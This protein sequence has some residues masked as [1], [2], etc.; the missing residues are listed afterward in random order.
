MLET[1]SAVVV[2]RS[3]VQVMNDALLVAGAAFVG[4]QFPAAALVWLDARRLNLERPHLYPVAIATVLLFGWLVVAAYIHRRD[5]LSRAD[6]RETVEAPRT[7]GWD[8]DDRLVWT[9]ELGGAAGLVRRLRHW[10]TVVSR[11]VWW[12]WFV[13]VPA[14][15]LTGILLVS[16][17]FA[18]LYLQFA[19]L[20]LVV[21]WGLSGWGTDA[22]LAMD[23]DAGAL[24]ITPLDGDPAE[25]REEYGLAELDS[26]RIVEHGEYAVVD[27]RYETRLLL[28]PGTFLVPADLTDDLAAA[29]RA[30]D[31]VVR[32]EHGVTESAVRR[33][34][35]AWLRLAVLLL[36]LG[37]GPVVAVL[38]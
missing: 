24:R 33:S 7:E 27:C 22:V 2:V 18:A 4:L 14:A 11:P 3:D 25:D 10:V 16:P 38:L 36:A 37:V 29:L 6:D 23:T 20:S 35:A 15:L 17:R 19:V 32:G 13:A 21:V 12:A 1:G 31:V 5:E 8:A 26:V 30:C 9:V 28:R 34:T